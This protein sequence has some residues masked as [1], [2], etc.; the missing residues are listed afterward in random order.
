MHKTVLQKQETLL[1]NEVQNSAVFVQLET[2][3]R[4]FDMEEFKIVD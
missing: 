3:G 1:Y 2:T 4:S